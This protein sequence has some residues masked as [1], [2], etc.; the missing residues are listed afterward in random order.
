M[1]KGKVAL[2]C[3]MKVYG[4]HRY[5][6]IHFQLHRMSV[7]GKFHVPAVLLPK[8]KPLVGLRNLDKR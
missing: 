4:E 6:S 3:A 5:R 8:K 1:M 2:V 7:S